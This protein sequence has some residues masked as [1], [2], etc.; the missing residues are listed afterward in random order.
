MHAEFLD[1]FRK[2]V[3]PMVGGLTLLDEFRLFNI[4]SLSLEAISL[5]PWL[6]LIECG[7]F[8]GGSAMI[9]QAALRTLSNPE[10][11]LHLFDTFQGLPEADPRFDLHKK[12]D[13]S[14]TSL[15]SVRRRL[16]NA[17]IHAGM[18]PET[19]SRLHYQDN[20]S[21]A[22]IDVDLKKSVE[23]CLSFI[24]PRLQLGGWIIIDDYEAEGCP[25]AKLATNEFFRDTITCLTLRGPHP[26]L[27]IQKK[28]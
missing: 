13:F 17:D 1:C 5:Y 16:P 18:I 24:W 19:F 8:M 9:M 2:E 26:T 11:S 27:M 28:L 12:G 14:D 21:F 20:F 23:D 3:L 15:E 6:H 4:W 25:G 22:H 10:S 7:V